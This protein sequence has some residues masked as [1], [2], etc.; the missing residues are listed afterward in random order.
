M[1]VSIKP[2]YTVEG[3]DFYLFCT[4]LGEDEDE[5]NQIRNATIEGGGVG[6]VFYYKDKINVIASLYTS[7]SDAQAV[8]EK[9]GGLVQTVT[10]PKIIS[11]D[12]NYITHVSNVYK[13]VI[14][15]VEKLTCAFIEFERGNE[16]ERVL[17]QIVRNFE[18]SLL[19]YDEEFFAI[20][21]NEVN[22]QLEIKDRCKLYCVKMVVCALQLDILS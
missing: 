6:E 9:N 7:M 17:E 4:Y 21:A 22:T 19:S 12:K 20:L 13:F 14:E 3:E 5:A 15:N 8:A 16:N 10:L 18:T 2:S 11:N 1:V